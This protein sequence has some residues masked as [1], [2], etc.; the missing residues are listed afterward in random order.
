[1][2]VGSTSI[3]NFGAR[4]GGTLNDAKIVRQS[5][6]VNSRYVGAGRGRGAV[7]EK[8]RVKCVSFQRQRERFA[9]EVAANFG[10]PWV[11]EMAG[12]GRRVDEMVSMVFAVR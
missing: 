11:V 7:G 8:R 10:V 4:T 1:M 9:K 3:G 12:E 6:N 2:N 5:R